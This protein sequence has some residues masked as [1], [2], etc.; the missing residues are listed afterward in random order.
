VFDIGVPHRLLAAQA[1]ANARR[2]ESFIGNAPEKGKSY[3]A[4]RML[5]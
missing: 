5:A 1:V 3:R 4:V 2:A